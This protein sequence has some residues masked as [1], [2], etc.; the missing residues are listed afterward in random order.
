MLKQRKGSDLLFSTIKNYVISFFIALVT[1]G[2][3]AFFVVAL[4]VNSIGGSFV[5]DPLG[6]AE[7]PETEV[8][9]SQNQDVNTLEGESL[10]VLAVITDFR[11]S[12]YG[13][14][15]YKH[16]SSML[17][18][19][20][21]TSIPSDVRPSPDSVMNLPSRPVPGSVDET[22]E[23]LNIIGGLVTN[24]LRTIHNDITVMIR[25]DKERKQFTFTYFPRY[26]V[27]S[28]NNRQ[29]YLRDIYHQYGVDALKNAVYSITGIRVDRHLLV[30]AKDVDELI[31]ALGGL[32]FAIP[33][34]IKYNDPEV[35]IDLDLDAGMNTL[36]GDTAAQI[37]LYDG[38]ERNNDASLERNGMSLIR[39]LIAKLT[40][41]S[42]YSSA[43]KMFSKML[44]YC[45][46]DMTL[47][48]ITA[49]KDLW[50]AY[51]TFSK[52]QLD[53]PGRWVT[54]GES[55]SFEISTTAKMFFEEYRKL[56][57]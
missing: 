38:Y 31:D 51:A 26:A 46:T 52:K 57:E 14:Y 30:H 10:Y 27:V 23:E 33:E 56:Y 4:V 53:V 44:P 54:V 41:P 12:F 24:D 55:I 6:D 35:G 15:D 5:F 40:Q 7:A 25:M 32:D 22:S 37:L 1:F 36:D 45:D 43:G 47:E 34:K 42:G 18:T 8:G 13:D 2:L 17:G 49:N 19:F 50:Y 20:G 48:D 11:P 16:I 39:A 28:Y 21:P 3:V 29:H 9:P